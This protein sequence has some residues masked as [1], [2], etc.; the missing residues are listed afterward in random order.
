MSKLTFHSE[1]YLP[2]PKRPTLA[3]QKLQL[4]KLA[5]PFR[6]PILKRPKVN[7]SESFESFVQPPQVN[8]A[9]SYE[10]KKESNASDMS[11]AQSPRAI[12]VDGRERHRTQRAAA[13]FKS[14]LVNEISPKFSSVR[15]TPTIQELERKVQVLKRAIKVKEQGEEETLKCLVG[16]WT[17][18]GREVAWEVWEL[19]KDNTNNEDQM[20]GRGKT[21]RGTF[22]TGWGWDEKCSDPGEK[23]WGLDEMESSECAMLPNGE[24]NMGVNEDCDE[25][26]GSDTVGT[27]LL[28]LGI[29]PETLGWNE[30][31]GIFQDA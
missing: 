26:K 4:K 28:Q 30:E 3:S 25:E 21:G 20:W 17:E 15:M 7:G 8:P 9:L 12:A 24:R 27:M 29:D 23:T 6:S 1:Q 2:N 5:K 13:Q 16:R 10:T 18:A 22:G 31:D 11:F 14:P 19:V